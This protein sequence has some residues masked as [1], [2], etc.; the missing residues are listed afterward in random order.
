MAKFSAKMMGKEVGQ[1]AKYAEPH[2][3]D[4]KRFGKE[5]AAAAV[6]VKTD[7][8][9]LCADQVNPRTL[10]MRVTIGNPGRDDVKTDGIEMRGAGA[11]TKGRMSRGP[12]A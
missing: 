8:N 11:A 6:S 9:T 10:A 3:M 5:T 1:A 7:P 12:M 4:G 2:S